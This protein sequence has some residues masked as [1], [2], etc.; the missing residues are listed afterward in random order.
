[1]TT[2]RCWCAR[3]SNSRSWHGTTLAMRISYT[4]FHAG[5]FLLKP[6][7][8]C[9]I[10]TF[11]DES[12]G[13]DFTQLEGPPGR[14]CRYG[15]IGGRGFDDSGYR[16]VRDRRTWP[17]RKWRREWWQRRHSE[18]RAGMSPSAPPQP[19][20]NALT[21]RLRSC[22]KLPTSAPVRGLE[23]VFTVLPYT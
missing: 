6:V 11:H 3:P 8:A 16:N 9:R 22:G 12:Q 23:D 4:A 15:R 5:S 13:T 2:S 21:G 1:M 17:G 20:T 18:W 7:K 10:R 19:R 14:R